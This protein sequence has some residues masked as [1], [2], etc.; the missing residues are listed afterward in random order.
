MAAQAR[1][2]QKPRSDIY[3][4]LLVLAFLAQ[5]VGFTF[6]AIDY[7]SYP[8]A[9]PPKVSLKPPA[10][11]APQAAPQGGAPVVPGQP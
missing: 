11:P 2:A 4:G 5:I 8:S 9:S 6:L 10:A 3:T 1:T 7:M